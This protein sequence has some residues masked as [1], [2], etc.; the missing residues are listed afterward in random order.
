M[1]I[2]VTGG[3][4]LLGN[5]LIRTLCAGG[6]DVVALIRQDPDPQVFQ[7]VEVA[8]ARSELVA[9]QD[10]SGSEGDALEA[11]IEA[12]DAVVHSAGMIH[13]G[14]QQ[15]DSSMRVNRDGTERIASA[16]RR[17][18]KKLVYVGTVDALAV[19][20]RQT[21]ADESTPITHAGGKI[22]CAYVQSKRAGLEVVR[23]GVTEGLNAVM[24]HPGFMLGPWDWKP[25]SGRMMLELAKGWKPIAPSGGCSLCDVRDV[26]QAIATAVRED[27]DPGREYIL[28]GHNWTYLKL[29]TEMAERMGKRPPIRRAGPGMEYLAGLFG[30]LWAWGSGKEPDVNSAGVKMSAQYHWYSSH[31]AE[32]ELN[33]QIRAAEQTLDDAA[34]WILERFILP[35][36]GSDS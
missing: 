28:A 22:P 4:G 26:A 19:A 9:S 25:S 23:R 24:V 7:G 36:K 11:A 30:D 16:C 13:I 15:M 27:I 20:S 14:W 10:S 2:L 1:K 33:Y 31:R 18:G 6:G 32:T 35:G 12:C 21:V 17:F 5:N 34:E 8:L 29:W 3:T